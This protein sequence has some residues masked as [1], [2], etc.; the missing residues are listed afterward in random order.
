MKR[1]IKVCMK[2]ANSKTIQPPKLRTIPEPLS[3]FLQKNWIEIGAFVSELPRP[4][5]NSQ[6]FKILLSGHISLQAFIYKI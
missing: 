1:D 5:T 2:K 4:Q 3:A 6:G